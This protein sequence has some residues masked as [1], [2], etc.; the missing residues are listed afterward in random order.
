M[1]IQLF[2]KEM[3]KETRK[4]AHLR[5]CKSTKIVKNFRIIQAYMTA[6]ISQQASDI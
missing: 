3:V 4:I 5:C 1:H 2:M 6:V